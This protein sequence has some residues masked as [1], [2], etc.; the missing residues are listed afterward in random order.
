MEFD[1]SGESIRITHPHN[2]ERGM[3]GV[4]RLNGEIASEFEIGEPGD[5][6][7]YHEEHFGRN[8]LH[9]NWRW[10]PR[11]GLEFWMGSNVDV[12]EYDSILRHIEKRLSCKLSYYGFIEICSL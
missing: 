3:F 8:D 12:E 11:D 6:V 5:P 2:P 10:T 1:Y 9:R 4:I 7:S